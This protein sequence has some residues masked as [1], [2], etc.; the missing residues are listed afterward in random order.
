MRKNRTKH[1]A[2]KPRLA[3]RALALCFALIFV[4][5][6]LLPA[7][8]NGDVATFE[9]PAAEEEQ[10]EE[11]GEPVTE[12]LYGTDDQT[13]VPTTQPGGGINMGGGIVVGDGDTTGG[14]TGGMIETTDKD[15]N[16]VYINPN[17]TESDEVLTP[18]DD[19]ADSV[20]ISRPEG[21]HALDK[22]DAGFSLPTNIYHFWLKEMSHYDLDDISSEAAS[23]D[24]TVEQY[25]AMYGKDTGCYHIMTAA[26]GADLND[27]KFANP[28]FLDDSEGRNF[29][30]WYTVDEFGVKHDFSFD[31]T[32]YI[33]SGTT[34]EVFAKWVAPVET[35]TS[36]N[37]KSVTVTVDGVA[38]AKR[39]DVEQS[40]NE[41]F[42]E[43][44]Y[45]DLADD[46]RVD[47]DGNS[48]YKNVDIHMFNVTPRDENYKAV[49]PAS[50]KKAT[51]TIEDMTLSSEDFKV[52]HWKNGELEDLTSTA[53]LENG[54]LTFKTSS[55]SDFAVVGLGAE[56]AEQPWGGGGEY[57]YGQTV[58]VYLKITGNT[59]GLVKHNNSTGDWFMIGKIDN[60]SL[61]ECNTGLYAEHRA[62][63]AN[64]G[65][66]Q[67]TAVAALNKIDRT[68]TG[69]AAVNYATAEDAKAAILANSGIDLSQV[70]W[71]GDLGLTASNGADGFVY[72]GNSTWHLDGT[73]SRQL[74]DSYVIRYY[75]KG[76]NNVI[77][78]EY[79]AN[80]SVGAVINISNN[81][82]LKPKTIVTEKGKAYQYD[83][84]PEGCITTIEMDG[85]RDGKN[86]INLYYVPKTMDIQITKVVTTGD[87]TKE[88]KFKVTGDGLGNQD[89][90]TLTDENNNKLDRINGFVMTNQKTVTLNNVESLMDV[91]VAEFDTYRFDVTASNYTTTPAVANAKGEK[92]F[93]YKVVADSDGDLVLVDKNGETVSNNHIFVFNN[94]ATTSLTVAKSASKDGVT[95]TTT[96]FNFTLTLGE[97]SLGATW[98][99]GAESGT[100]DSSPY[101]FKLKGG[102]SITFTGIN[103]YDDNVNVTE[104]DYSAQHYITTVNGNTG[105]EI[106][107]TSETLKSR[108][109]AGV[110]ANFVNAYT[111]PKLPSMTITKNVTGEFGERDKNFTFKVELTDEAGNPVTGVYQS[112]ENLNNFTLKHGQYVTLNQIPVGTKITIT[113]TN[114]DGYKTKATNHDTFTKEDAT[115]RVFKYKVVEEGGVAVLK[116]DGSFL[117]LAD[118]AVD[119]NAIIVTNEKKG[120]P[121]TG[122][123]LDTLPYLIILGIAVAGAAAL[124]IRK[125]KHDDE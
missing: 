115:E 67:T 107:F 93:N 41:S 52:Y 46:L 80:A 35:T 21:E 29:A 9:A 32:L 69:T 12:D 70:N 68:G 103:V 71:E 105:N 42:Y 57:L 119:Q 99:K 60:V 102:E 86:V 22:V 76:T 50:G 1:E 63:T 18:S 20:I 54:T 120:D 17:V 123:L 34:V 27:Y 62:R 24:M 66:Y 47:E 5:S 40:E 48:K 44:I 7:F 13:N 85:Y 61:P 75:E 118:K 81:E 98:T 36:I 83:S 23:R 112:V 95:D 10:T 58:Y 53:T 51:V 111:T 77:K 108:Q 88:F 55:F 90:R 114:A 94:P 8:A 31:Q 38:D 106:A 87:N 100:V 73:L 110:A 89:K 30:G 26:D 109:T 28:T 56:V 59:S 64:N 125:K 96:E 15:G 19:P 11:T 113:E 97:K 79:R 39:L 14:T 49:Q 4:C 121:D 16:I 74:V 91:N 78:T 117:D 84:S 25:L 72:A 104:A 116:S 3:K 45:N 2:K 33:T 122:V 43:E 65:S 101:T 82:E 124:L 6:C 92:T 37:A